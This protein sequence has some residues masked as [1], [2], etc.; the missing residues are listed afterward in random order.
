[1]RFIDKLRAFGAHTLNGFVEN[2]KHLIK[3]VVLVLCS[4]V[5]VFQLSE[6]FAKLLNPPIATH[7]F[8]NLNET[9]TYPALTFCHNPPYNPQQLRY[10]RLQIHPEMTNHWR[11]FNYTQ[12]PDLAAVFE[13]MTYGVQESVIVAGLDK[14]LPSKK[15]SN[16][17]YNIATK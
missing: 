17:I 2:P 10:Y 7:S 3:Y 12:H 8:F 15:T 16:I 6:C 1:M 14:D 9:M 13:N 4:I 5:V 11:D